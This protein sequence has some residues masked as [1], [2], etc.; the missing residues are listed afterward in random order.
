MS[1][2]DSLVVVPRRRSNIPD[3]VNELARTL[4]GQQ[5]EKDEKA[6]Y[7]DSVERQRAMLLAKEFNALRPEQ[8]AARYAALDPLT[9]QYVDDPAAIPPPVLSDLEYRK[10]QLEMEKLTNQQRA[11]IDRKNLGPGGYESVMH[12][13]LTGGDN[14]GG[15]VSGATVA[16]AI[17]S[18]PNDYAPQMQNRQRIT[19]KIDPTGQESIVHRD[20][21]LP[22]TRAEIAE[23]NA[24]T[25]KARAETGQIGAAQPTIPGAG[26]ELMGE[27]FLATLN[28]TAREIV[29]KIANY[30]LDLTKIAS[31][32]NPKNTESERKML[33]GL[34]SRYDPTYDMTQFAA[35][36]KSRQDFTSGNAARNIRSLNTAVKHLAA[37]EQT[38]KAL[39]NA[40]LPA[41][42][43]VANT[44]SRQSGD[45]RVTNFKSALTAVTDELA[46]LFKG[47]AGTDEQIKHWRASVSENMSPEQMKGQMETLAELVSGRL[48]ALESQYESIMGRPAP[49]GA[50]LSNESRNILERMGLLDVM[51]EGR[52]VTEPEAPSA[53][54]SPRRKRTVRSLDEKTGTFTT[55][56]VDD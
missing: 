38:G 6:R 46:T 12:N 7:S 52:V 35:R 10:E 53:F 43:A 51:T 47:T 15:D 54:Q 22:K 26:G 14:P 32:R 33:A 18:N 21:T 1:T 56:Q 17:Y 20:V 19:D 4:R 23:T 45:K 3:L 11:L 2:A 44:L 42:N 31:L 37:L 39:D 9:R 8:K 40:R 41:Y 25:A 49:P 27:E 36:N 34:V 30:E 29:R 55:K 16:N 28:P 50:I 13:L 48:A 5:A 24:K